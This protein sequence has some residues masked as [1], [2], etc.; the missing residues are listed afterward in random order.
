[1]KSILLIIAFVYSVNLGIAQEL[2]VPN[3]LKQFVEQSFV[4]YPKVA[5]MK[6]LVSLNEVRLRLDKTALLPTAMGDLS[7]RLQYPTPIIQF[8]GEGGKL[9]EI[10][11]QPND[12][13]NAGIT[14]AQPL[15]DMRLNSVLN[16]AKSDINLSKDNL[17]GFKLTLAYQVAQIY[18]SIIFLNKS[19]TVQLEQIKLLQSTLEQIAVKVKNGDALQYDLVSTE[20][21]YTNAVNFN[22]DLIGQLNKQYNMLGMLTGL[23]GKDYL[24]ETSFNSS[25]FNLITD[26]VS[27]F[28]L[29]NNPDIRIAGDKIKSASWDILTAE[30]SRMPAVNLQAGMG[31]RN[32]YM[33]N[34]DLV[35]FNYFVGLGITIPILSGSR[36]GFQRKLAVIN[37]DA[38]QMALET[39]KVVLNKDLL[40]ALEDIYRNKKKLASADTLIK[41]AQ[42]ANNIAG[43]RYKFGVITNLD[44]LTTVTNFKDAQLSQLQFEYNL[45]VS[46]LD[47]C[48]LA[49]IR[50]W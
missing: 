40:N 4:K 32:G 16:K 31:Y 3:E 20:V 17:E 19:I 7:Y 47:L 8:P 41:Q 29:R 46:R 34:I 45:L 38:T 48:R 35:N 6:D 42:M 39:Q 2:I 28:A 18:Y 15:I 24:N 27:S 36:P 37:H 22:T 49:G 10:K 33:P 50:W 1:M 26:S 5:E 21:K 11:I 14:L 25:V 9:Q 23:N 30:R 43:E 12:N 44:L 13:Y